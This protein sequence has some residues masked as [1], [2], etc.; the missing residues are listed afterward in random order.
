MHTGTLGD[1]MLRVGHHKQAFAP[2]VPLF[3]EEVERQGGKVHISR[4]RL[5]ATFNKQRYVFHLG[6]D[7][8]VD[9]RRRASL[10][11]V[12]KVD[13]DKLSAVLHKVNDRHGYNE[14]HHRVERIAAKIRYDSQR[15]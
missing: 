6:S 1:M 2:F 14:V 7:N 10:D 8:T 13:V 12:L 5:Q 9:V 15:K 3:I 4:S 11:S